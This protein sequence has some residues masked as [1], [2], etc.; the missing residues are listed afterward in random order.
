MRCAVCVR[1][2]AFW[3]RGGA[4]SASTSPGSPPLSDSSVTPEGIRGL[5]RSQLNLQI[6]VLVNAV[7]D[8]SIRRLQRYF[9]AS[10]A[11]AHQGELLTQ[12]LADTVVAEQGRKTRQAAPKHR[13]QKGGT[14]RVDQARNIAIAKMEM[15]AK[16]EASRGT[17]PRKLKVAP[18]TPI[19]ERPLTPVIIASDS[20]SEASMVLQSPQPQ[21]LPTATFETLR[22]TRL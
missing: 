18:K 9:K 19:P 10:A 14:L 1:L 20:E 7:P 21:A 2:V 11:F 8:T 12:R 13:L 5:L 17:R 3:G 4:E 15:K 16:K 6:D 22:A